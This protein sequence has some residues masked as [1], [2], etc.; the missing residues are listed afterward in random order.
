MDDRLKRSFFNRPTL[1][2][3]RDLLGRRLVRLDG[4]LRMA[5]LITETEAYCGEADLACHARA[6]RTP[7]TAVMYGPAGHA[8]VYFSY[9]MHWLLNVVTES[10][11][12]PGAVL[13]R[14]ME[15]VEGL[16]RIAARRAGRPRSAWTDGPAKLCQALHITGEQ[17]GIDLT[18]PEASLFLELGAP[19]EED[20]VATGPRVGIDSVPE[21]W[22]SKPWRYRVSP[23]AWSTA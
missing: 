23:A 7:R 9:G 4:S 3:A 6:G 14:G 19:V 8:Y 13:I 10:P 1:Q 16:E 18:A 22:K 15:A 11:G 20:Q 5:G 21:P 2:V 17:N 12:E